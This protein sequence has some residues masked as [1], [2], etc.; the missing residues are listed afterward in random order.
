MLMPLGFHITEVS[1]SLTVMEHLQQETENGKAPDLIMLDVSMPG[2]SGWEVAAQLRAAGYREPIIMVSADASEGRSRH[3][4]TSEQPP[5][6]DAYVIKPVRFNL[7]LEPIGRLLNLT[8]CYDKPQPV[9]QPSSSARIPVLQL[10]DEIHIRR[11][12]QLSAIGHKK[13]LQDYLQQLKDQQQAQSEFIDVLTNLA[14]NFQFE[15]IINLL[16][17]HS[18]ES[19]GVNYEQS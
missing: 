9:I 5:L 1:N 17:Q 6:H 4:D 7:L 14:N 2:L 16:D 11:I 15:K 19:A 3:A 10:P 13:G 12:Q 8:W 18:T